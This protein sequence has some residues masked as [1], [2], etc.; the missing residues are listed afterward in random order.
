MLCSAFTPGVLRVLAF[1][2][3]QACL[4]LLAINMTGARIAYKT[5]A[6]ALD[7][8]LQPCRKSCAHKP[9]RT[10][11]ADRTGMAEMKNRFPARNAEVLR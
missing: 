7:E 5:E 9:C 10:G 4:N 6:R 8:S 11:M 3:R 1:P 2:N